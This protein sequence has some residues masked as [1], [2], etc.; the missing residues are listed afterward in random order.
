MVKCCAPCHFIRTGDIFALRRTRLSTTFSTYWSHCVGKTMSIRSCQ[1]LI[2]TIMLHCYF[3]ANQFFTAQKI[4]N[5]TRF[6]I[7]TNILKWPTTTPLLLHLRS[8][9]NLRYPIS[10][11]QHLR[12]PHPTQCRGYSSWWGIRP[13]TRIWA[14]LIQTFPFLPFWSINVLLHPAWLSSELCYS[15]KSFTSCFH[16]I[17]HISYTAITEQSQKGHARTHW[18]I[19]FQ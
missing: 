13:H 9:L 6:P 18:F 2:I 16:T 15:L 1:A 17:G 4:N 3:N 19:I 11:L 5:S 8:A 7:F 14:H 10:C 12:A